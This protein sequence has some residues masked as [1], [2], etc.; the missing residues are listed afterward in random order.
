MRMQSELLEQPRPDETYDTSQ[1]LGLALRAAGVPRCFGI[2]GVQNLRLYEMFGRGVVEPVLIAN[3]ASAAYLAAGQYQGSGQPGCINV[4]GGP[5]I[6][7]ALP[8][9]EF[10]F[11][12]R[13]PLFILTTG[14]ARD[15]GR[16]HQLHDV[17]NLGVLAPLCKA[18]HRL[19][20]DDDVHD[21]VA[22]LMEAAHGEVPGPCA[23]EVPMHLLR[24]T[25]KFRERA[26]PPRAFGGT[27]AWRNPE[28]PAALVSALEACA[29]AVGRVGL[30]VVSDLDH[31]RVPSRRGAVALALGAAFSQKLAVAVTD[32]DSLLAFAPELALATGRRLPLVI[33]VERDPSEAA[34]IELIAGLTRVRRIRST[35]EAALARELVEALHTPQV[36]LCEIERAEARVAAPEPV[37]LGVPW[38][39]AFQQGL[40]DS[41]LGAVFIAGDGR[42]QAVAEALS[43]DGVPVRTVRHDQDLGFVADGAARSSKR[44][45]ALILPEEWALSSV[46]S[47]VGEA[48]LDQVP[49]VVLIVTSTRPGPWL[50]TLKHLSKSA[51]IVASVEDMAGAIQEAV[52]LSLGSA[53][54]PV[55]LVCPADL[56][57]SAPGVMPSRRREPVLA[58]SLP[59]EAGL[60]AVAQM[61]VRAKQ[62]VIFVGR[63]AREGSAEL[64]ALAHRTGA[65]VASTLS[66]KGVFPE[67]DPLWLWG[68]FGPLSPPPMKAIAEDCD[69]ALIIG[70]RLSELGSAHY[71]ARFP[72]DCFHVD[73][74]PT[75]P[76][77]ATAAMGITADARAFLQALLKHLDR[78]YRAD[79]PR[80]ADGVRARLQAAHAWVDEDVRGRSQEG[81]GLDPYALVRTVQEQLPPETLFCA[82]SGNG[83]I[84][85]LEAL[86]L[87]APDRF[88][89]PADFNSMG[90][91]V[92]AALGAAWAH[93]SVPVVAFVGDGAFLMTGLK[94]LMG[95]PGAPALI[96]VVLRDRRLGMIGDI[97]RATN[98]PEVCTQLSDFDLEAFK[99][100]RPE[101]RF[102]SVSTPDALARSVQAARAAWAQGCGTL[103]ECRVDPET[104]S[105]FFKGALSSAAVPVSRKVPRLPAVEGPPADVWSVIERAK[106]RYAERVAIRDGD[107]QSTYGEL[108]A[109]AAGLAQFF[110]EQGVGPGSVVGVMLRNR[111]EVVETHFAAAGLRAVVL[112]VNVRLTARELHDIFRQSGMRWL[113]TSTDFAPTLSETL[114]LGDLRLGGV[115]WVGPGQVPEGTGSFGTM[116]GYEEALTASATPFVPAQGS[117]FDAFHLYYTSGTTGFPKGVLLTHRQV[118]HHAIATAEEMRITGDDVWGH[119]SPMYHVV[120]AFAIYALTWLGGQHVMVS[121]PDPTR[122]LRLLAEERITCTNLAAAAAHFLIHSPDLGTH[123]FSRLR[124]LSCGGSAL[125][126]GA[127]ARLIQI[128]GCEIFMSYG[129]TECCGKISMSLLSEEHR[130]L[131][132]DA[133]FERIATSGRPFK[134]M[135]VRIV[136]ERGA[137]VARDNQSM[138]E[139][140]IR[141]LTVFSGYFNDGPA[142]RE[143]FQDG[144]FKTGD[145]AT[146]RPD[147]Y[148]TIAGRKKD[149]LITYGENVYPGEVERVLGMHPGVQQVA[150]YGIPNPTAGEVVKAVIRLRA[151]HALSAREA[152]AFCRGHLAGYKVPSEVEF[153]DEMPMTGTFKVDKLRLKNREARALPTGGAVP[154]ASAGASRGLPRTAVIERVTKIVGDLRVSTEEPV[155]TTATLW[156]LG[157]DSILFLTLLR[158]LEG[159]FQLKLD[160]NFLVQNNTIEMIAR[161]I[162]Q[163]PVEVPGAGPA[164]REAPPLLNDALVASWS[165]T[166]QRPLGGFESLVYQA[167]RRG[168][169]HINPVVEMEGPVDPAR[170]REAALLLEKRY[171]Y[172]ST[173]IVEK[174]TGEFFL[175]YQPGRHLELVFL[176]E[177]GPEPLEQLVA[178]HLRD[179]AQKK[180]LFIRTQQAPEIH[181]V[182]PIL[183]HCYLEVHAFLRL[184]RDLFEIHEQLSTGAPVDVKAQPLPVSREDLFSRLP[185]MG[186]G[187]TEPNPD[188][189]IAKSGQEVLSSLEVFRVNK[190]K[191]PFGAQK[192]RG[193]AISV[194]GASRSLAMDRD[195]TRNVLGAVVRQQSSVTGALSAA[196]CLVAR[197]LFCPAPRPHRMILGGSFDA[198]P[199]LNLPTDAM[200]YY[201]TYPKFLVNVGPQTGFWDLAR[202]FHA[203]NQ[204]YIDKR[205]YAGME[206]EH[207]HTLANA[208]KGVA[209]LLWVPG[210]WELFTAPGRLFV[211]NLGVLESGLGRFKLR[212]VKVLQDIPALAV[213]C[214]VL[215]GSLHLQLCSQL[216]PEAADRF[217]GHLEEHFRGLSAPAATQ[218]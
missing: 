81:R 82:D 162:A 5:G 9:I 38:L 153:I 29:V 20:E 113:V 154:G 30:H 64:V 18:T 150:V 163:A 15:E 181:Q 97:Q 155:S 179:N 121:D 101:L 109:R 102:E 209:K 32:A 58:A 148:L 63:G 51:T 140:W 36:V 111:A 62:P 4:I 186:L 44:P 96:T 6:T 202:S 207:F 43:S 146:I 23:L 53:P 3:E 126:A 84:H 21:V 147:G 189:G 208:F 210:M 171:P 173:A 42:L 114:A 59:S 14:C 54:G 198:R 135:D 183:W 177:P 176:S 90:Y 131:S 184:V 164:A 94:G 192:K 56:A 67:T 203:E 100:K 200:G 206:A 10:A 165:A 83:T 122:F 191:A 75:V 123:D 188:A 159:A 127:V 104:K 74:D 65:V 49:L 116:R 218:G 178:H 93:P 160:P 169:L 174:A 70:A 35:G 196:L 60:D 199:L 182:I 86:R 22:R 175:E 91:S 41:D 136:D 57:A 194:A 69:G 161:A 125:D 99:D 143:A 215:D 195:A 92:P 40:R 212:G 11:R 142:T 48:H 157:L 130:K 27:S 72:A 77:K 211:V 98:R 73:I 8:G 89:C 108:H 133:Q 80:S 76:N 117:E 7:H 193:T 52:Q 138:G 26:Q 115:L 39:A 167:N 19:T 197:D 139:V 170:M 37:A 141:G 28:L 190:F 185:G 214:Y 68:G 55:C 85:A 137:D 103:I 46:L 144:W 152:I 216:P 95:E 132:Q 134:L 119:F 151:G 120:D 66:G 204:A 50:G 105:Y 145:L 158:E 1:L 166:V 24:R 156:S 205:T 25:S 47:G 213:Y 61:F 16:A 217:A 33:L 107:R 17:D 118:F 112:N 71:R 168:L 110:R 187:P 13:T 180:I 129:M 12:T 2:P 128:F 124:I 106:A 79:F 88:L 31:Q 87:T 45:A 149:M 201:A 78:H 34:S 172:L